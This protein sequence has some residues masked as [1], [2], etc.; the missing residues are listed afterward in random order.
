MFF[1]IVSFNCFHI[2]HAFLRISDESR[3]FHIDYLLPRNFHLK[4]EQLFF[5]NDSYKMDKVA[6]AC[7]C[8]RK[9]IQMHRRS[10]KGCSLLSDSSH[11]ALLRSMPTPI[12]PM[13]PGYGA[14][15]T[16]LPTYSSIA[17]KTASFSKVPPCTT[18]LSLQEN[19]DLIRG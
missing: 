6:F 2:P 3:L 12:A 7:C 16:S 18:I 19:Q 8:I 10:H 4:I 17:R 5:D 13:I 11:I 9:C 15:I 14:L 1:R